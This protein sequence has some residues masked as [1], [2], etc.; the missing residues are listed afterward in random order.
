MD[1]FDANRKIAQAE[2]KSQA[3]VWAGKF[4]PGGSASKLSARDMYS[5]LSA[6]QGHFANAGLAPL[7]RSAEGTISANV[8]KTLDLVKQGK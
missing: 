6:L 7:P 3:A 5:A 8:A 4:A 1:P 2:L